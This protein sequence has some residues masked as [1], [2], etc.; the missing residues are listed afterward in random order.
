MCGLL[1]PTDIVS[2][3]AAPAVSLHKFPACSDDPKFKDLGTG[4]ELYLLNSWM[5][6]SEDCLP[7]RDDDMPNQATDIR[8]AV[9]SDDQDKARLALRDFR[10]E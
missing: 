7:K 5:Q 9:G 1:L 10:F 4:I 3:P 6:M 2:L 8:R